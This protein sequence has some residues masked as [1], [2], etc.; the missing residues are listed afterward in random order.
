MSN[1]LE[2]ASK[3]GKDTVLCQLEKNN[4]T[5]GLYQTQQRCGNGVSRYSFTDPVY[6]VWINDGW[7]LSCMSYLAAEAFYEKRIREVGL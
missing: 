3:F 2:W 7:E 5:T 1:L 6:H 4:E